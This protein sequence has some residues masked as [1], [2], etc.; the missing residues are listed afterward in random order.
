MSPST[1]TFKETIMAMK[2]LFATVLITSATLFV[3]SAAIAV[4]T[5]EP[6]GNQ[7]IES[8]A[9]RTIKLDSKTKSVQIQQGETVK[10][11]FEGKSFVWQFN[12][13]NTN[14]FKFAEIAPSDMNVKN[15]QV[16]LTRN[17]MYL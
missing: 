9:Q 13:L 11:V 16:Y 15:I 3:S 14:T 6:Y 5:T 7:S 10:F 17:P 8:M 2:K 12:T 1:L 4:H